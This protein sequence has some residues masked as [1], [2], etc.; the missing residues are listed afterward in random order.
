ML[1]VL[2]KL[3]FTHQKGTTRLPPRRFAIL[4]TLYYY[5]GWWVGHLCRR[6]SALLSGIVGQKIA[7]DV[8]V[9]LC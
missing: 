4:G 8:A 3:G 1:L 6:N 2:G 7:P 5:R 9:L